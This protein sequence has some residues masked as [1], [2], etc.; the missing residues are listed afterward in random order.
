MKLLLQGICCLLAIQSIAQEPAW[1]KIYRAT[2][3]K[4]MNMVHTRLDV[5]FDYTQSRM[6][7]KA[8]LTITPHFYATDSAI[9]DAKGMLIHEVSLISGKEKK[10]LAFN[11]KDSMVLRIK[12]DRVYRQGEKP[13]IYI[14]YTA[15]P[16]ELKVKG[17]AAIQDAKGLYFINPQGKDST[18]PI[19][20]W[21]QGETE[22]TSVWCPTVDRPN[23]KTTQEISMTVPDKYVTLSNG[24]LTK[25][26]KNNDGTRTDTWK[27]DLPHAPYLMFMGVG[28]YAVI[29]DKYKNIPVDYYVE[30]EY[31]P[32]AKRI[33][34]DTPDMIAFFE[35]LLGTPYPW[36][37]YAQF[38]GQEYVSGAM[39]NTTAT[40]HGPWS[41]QS[42]RQLVDENAWEPVIAHELFHQWFGDLVT[43]ESWSNLTVNE[44]FADYSE[45]LWM[46][47]KYGRDAADE[48][49]L[50][51]M[52]GYLNNPNEEAKHLVRFFYRDKEDMFDQVSYQKGGRILHMLLYELGD[53]AF[54]KGLQLYLQ[55]N[56]FK[57]AEAHQLRLALEEVTGRDL[58]PFFNQWY[59]NNGHPKINISYG[60]KENK[61]YVAFEQTQSDK[62][63]SLPLQIAVYAANEKPVLIPYTLSEKTDTFFFAHEG[64]KLHYEADADRIM[65]W[66][67]KETKTAD[68]WLAQ[69]KRMGNYISRKEALTGMMSLDTLGENTRQLMLTALSDPYHG[70]RVRAL[71][72]FLQYP[73]QLKTSAD[74][75]KAEEIAGREKHKATLATALD[76]LSKKEGD[77]Y[78][79]LFKKATTDS[80]Y[81]VAGAGLEALMQKDLNAAMEMST[82]LKKDA[83]GRLQQSLTILDIASKPESE[84]D[85]V[86]ADYKK[87]PGME[88]LFATK[89]MIFYAQKITDPVKFK[90]VVA[91]VVDLYRRIPPGIGNYKSDMLIQM[92][93]L[94]LFKEKQLAKNSG[95]ENLSEQITWLKNQIQ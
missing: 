65:L 80:S 89:G 77:Q 58:N 78:V 35:K 64:K 49:H 14:D 44:S 45:Y 40:I 26:V 84:A 41:Q 75:A 42:A 5:R 94:L 74:W 92:Q 1:K 30:K 32:V 21:T 13:V 24:L 38:V 88:R 57:A 2:P 7:G 33:F 20:I 43:T 51:A 54:F 69:Y 37:K 71:R 61:D 11:Y 19:Q 8:W 34:G 47:H 62:L 63:Y 48:Y 25:Q 52:T 27:M 91:P 3:E 23:Q 6:S 82:E 18:K 66:D 53:S 95:D 56:R 67:K 12:L 90:N 59:F 39:E 70:I 76:V 86:I 15:R 68:Q 9:L 72:Y 22:A 10:P 17:S 73:A 85:N 28:D 31:A 50:N 4:T 55:Q 87:L 16:N 93:D 29:R 60:Q 83:E 36:P 46:E 79:S 81:T